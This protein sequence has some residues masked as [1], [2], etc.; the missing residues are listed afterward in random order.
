MISLRQWEKRTLTDA[1]LGTSLQFTNPSKQYPI[2]KI[3][4]VLKGL[5]TILAGGAAD[6]VTNNL[7]FPRIVRNILFRTGGA[8]IL[9][10]IPGYAS[11]MQTNMWFPTDVI[12]TFPA[13]GTTLG[14][15]ATAYIQVPFSI[16]F[17]DPDEMV[18]RDGTIL[19][20]SRYED[21][22]CQITLD[23]LGNVCAS[24]D[25]PYTFAGT[26]SLM[27]E[28][29]WDLG[30]TANDV[31]REWTKSVTS[32]GVLEFDLPTGNL[33]SRI[34]EFQLTDGAPALFSND[35]VKIELNDGATVLY[36]GDNDQFVLWNTED[37]ESIN[38]VE[39][40]NGLTPFNLNGNHGLNQMMDNR[41]LAKWKLKQ[42]VIAPV[43]PVTHD[44]VLHYIGRAKAL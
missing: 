17:S 8:N 21:I 32:T 27:L 28:Q 5:F 23:T 24:G 6:Y 10:D 11:Y 18:A 36:E 33:I 15:G 19:I 31:L 34:N 30:V 9:K 4:V 43:P 25:R 14:V 7:T 38:V 44:I 40:Y 16:C 29:E 37:M 3:N 12:T 20:P 1:D 35:L 42:N 39:Y 22:L 2:R 41:Q 26:I 13:S